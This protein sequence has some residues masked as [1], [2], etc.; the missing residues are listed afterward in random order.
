MPSLLLHTKDNI[1]RFVEKLVLLI[2]KSI[3]A[4]TSLQKITIQF[5]PRFNSEYKVAQMRICQL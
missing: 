4:F 2:S 3:E 1:D 5:K